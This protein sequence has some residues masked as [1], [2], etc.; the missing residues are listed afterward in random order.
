MLRSIPIL[1]LL[2][3]VWIKV[4]CRQRE[5]SIVTGIR[6]APVPVPLSEV[7]RWIELVPFLL[8]V[9]GVSLSVFCSVGMTAWVRPVVTSVIHDDP[10]TPTVKNRKCLQ[11][12]I[13]RKKV[14]NVCYTY[15]SHIPA[16]VKVHPQMPHHSMGNSQHEL[17]TNRYDN[18]RI[19][20]TKYCDP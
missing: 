15:S 1:I 19:K 4:R 10:L 11:S 18:K 12:L 6:M 9:A 2:T 3:V 20:F 7:R 5:M 14:A 13:R 17:I 8:R 16:A